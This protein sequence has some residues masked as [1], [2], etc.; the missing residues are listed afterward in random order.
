MIRTLRTFTILMAFTCTLVAAAS[1]QTSPTLAWDEDPTSSV[2][3]YAL[4]IDGVRVD[5]GTA[6]LSASGSC[7]CSIALPFSGGS[8]TVVVSAYNTFGET[9]SAPLVLQPV[10]NAGGPYTT[11]PGTALFVNGAGSYDPTGT[12]TG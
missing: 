6:P 2:T 1:A 7:G 5:Y 3:G 4:T 8:H 12:I 9:P 10:A 11:Q